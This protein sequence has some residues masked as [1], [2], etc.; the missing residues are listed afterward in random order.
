MNTG[1]RKKTDRKIKPVTQISRKADG[2]SD[3]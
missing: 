1:A 2:E 3:R